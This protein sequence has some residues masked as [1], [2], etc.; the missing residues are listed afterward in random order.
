MSSTAATITAGAGDS[1]KGVAKGAVAGLTLGIGQSIFG[2]LLGTII[3]AIGAGMILKGQ[4]E[5][6]AFLAG[7][8]LVA[9][10]VGSASASA[11]SSGTNEG[12]L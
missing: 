1:L 8:M 9:G 5:M 3:G 12:V 4:R 11:S 7:W 10:S 6:I 2:N